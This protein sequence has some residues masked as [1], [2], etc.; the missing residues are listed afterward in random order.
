MKF[1]VQRGIRGKKRDQYAQRRWKMRR[2]SGRKGEDR[3]E[4]T[5][6]DPSR[7]HELSIGDM[8]GEQCGVCGS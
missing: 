6:E 7:K 2:G 4:Q 1:W 8:H 3:G 5:T